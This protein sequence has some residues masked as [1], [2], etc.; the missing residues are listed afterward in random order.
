MHH[1]TYC[2]QPQNRKVFSIVTEY[3]SKRV[4]LIT[5]WFPAD[6]AKRGLMNELADA[7]V[8]SGAQIDV[9]ALDW[10]TVDVQR[11]TNASHQTEGMNVYRFS[12]LVLDNVGKT[13]MLLLKWIV[14][15]LKSA[16]TTIRLLRKHQYDVI[17]SGLPSSV[18]APIAICFLFS[19]TKKYLVQWDF[20]PFHHRAIGL[21][22]G[23]P[24]YYIS[25]SLER[26]L[27]RGFNV[28]GCMS[29]KNI[30]FLRANYWIRKRQKVEVLPIWTVAE[31]PRKANR[32]ALRTK[33]GLPPKKKIAVFGGT[34]SKGRGL[35]DILA[36]AR[37]A[38]KQSPDI[39]FLIIGRGPLEEEVRQKSALLPNFKLMRS[40]PR[41]DYLAL[42]G[43]CDCGIVA[44]QR[45]TGVP[46]F[47][48]K[49]LDYFRAGI[50]VVASIEDSTDYGEFLS[51]NNAAIVVQAGDHHGLLESIANIGSLQPTVVSNGKRLISNHFNVDHT[52][53]QLLTS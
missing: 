4:L 15:P 37:I 49:I 40:I 39:L 23:G 33:Y 20:F 24:A 53:Q 34:L 6:V 50:P 42:L 16:F 9:I 41:Q 11:L 51:L 7:V 25:L 32:K 2:V 46:T 31:F 27:I 28:I 43:V 1:V 52:V 19:R 8:R 18:W 5:S 38:I 47:P 36:A 48:S 3:E 22:S 14:T 30:E 29:E 21:M 17:V 44:T 26:I 13:T 35:D 10:R 45:G 12:P